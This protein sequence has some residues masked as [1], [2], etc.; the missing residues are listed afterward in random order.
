MVIDSGIEIELISYSSGDWFKS[1]PSRYGFEV[2]FWATNSSGKKAYKL[3]CTEN[4][5]LTV[6]TTTETENDG[7]LDDLKAEEIAELIEVAKGATKSFEYFW[8]QNYREKTE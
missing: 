5:R 7:S 3:I 1:E 4:D 2:C 6:V 8:L